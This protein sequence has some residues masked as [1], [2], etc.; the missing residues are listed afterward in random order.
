[1]TKKSTRENIE[2]KAQER[3]HLLV[4]FPEHYESVRESRIGL[5]CVVCKNTWETTVHN[6]NCSKNGCLVCKKRITSLTHSKKQ[7]SVE[8]RRLISQK[9]SSR[10]GSLKGVRGEKHPRWKNGYGRDKNK[11]SYQDYEWKNQV[12]KRFYSR[13]VVTSKTS[14]LH[15]HH[16]DSWNAHPEKRY[17]PQ[18]GVLLHKTVHKHFHDIYKYGDNSESQFVQFLQDYYQLSWVQIRAQYDK[19]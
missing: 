3:N 19:K 17:D 10:A 2:L 11:Q 15:S 7:V 18:N 13:C 16:L 9:A 12:K 4:H 8:T 1:M 5:Y 14:Q 6:Y